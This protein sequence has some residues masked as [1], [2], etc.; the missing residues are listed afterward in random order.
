MIQDGPDIYI[1]TYSPRYIFTSDG[2]HV[3]TS[4]ITNL[5][6]K[7]SEIQFIHFI[8][9]HITSFFG[10]LTCSLLFCSD[11]LYPCCFD[12]DGSI[13]CD[14]CRLGVYRI[15]HVSLSRCIVCLQ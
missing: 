12:I 4:I 11:T 5:L 6:K 13:D 2:F 3:S 14:V 10:L 7:P 1:Y 9:H 8:H 15:Y